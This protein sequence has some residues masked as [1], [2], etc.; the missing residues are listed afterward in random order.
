MLGACPP[1]AIPLLDPLQACQDS[2]R[3]RVLQRAGLMAPVIEAK[4]CSLQPASNLPLHKGQFC[5]SE[6]QQADL[7]PGPCDITGSSLAETTMAF[8]MVRWEAGSL[9]RVEGAEPS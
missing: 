2:P 8:H 7:D 1:P 9:D 6:G 4:L 3:S 5:H